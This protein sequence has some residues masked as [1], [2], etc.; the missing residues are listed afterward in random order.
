MKNMSKMIEIAG[1]FS[2]PPD[3]RINAL[4]ELS[5]YPC[6]ESFEVAMKSSLVDPV[7]E[8]RW[9]AVEVVRAIDV[10]SAHERYRKSLNHANARIL[11][12]SIYA[13][14]QLG[15]HPMETI[16]MILELAGHEDRF[17]KEAVKNVVAKLAAGQKHFGRSGAGGGRRGPSTGRITG[18]NDGTM[19]GWFRNSV[20]VRAARPSLKVTGHSAAV[21]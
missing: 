18:T 5:D 8:V 10:G 4:Q 20:G 16:E 3:E 19:G 1:T 7:L 13:L 21:I 17:V 14:G 9:K 2:Y 11:E 15:I 12:R 6:R